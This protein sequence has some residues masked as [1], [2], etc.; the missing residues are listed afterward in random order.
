MGMDLA[1]QSWTGTSTYGILI[2]SEVDVSNRSSIDRTGMSDTFL[3]IF[4][5]ESGNPSQERHYTVAA[6]WCLSPRS[7]TREVLGPTKDRLIASLDCSPSELKGAALSPDTLDVIVPD[8]TTHGYDDTTIRHQRVPWATSK[9]IR[10]T[11]HDANPEL[12]KEVVSDI[13]GTPLKAAELLQTL[14]LASLLTPIF[15]PDQLQQ[16]MFAE[17]KVV[18]DSETWQRP[19]DRIESGIETL[20]MSVPESLSFEIQDSKAAPGIQIS[21]LT[22]YCWLRNRRNDD[23]NEAVNGI[24]NRRFGTF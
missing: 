17:T 1:V 21:D 6:T 13:T 20:D 2:K 18:L 23:C 9:P 8:I 4:V 14:S 15:Y 16:D 3:Y 24:D 22:A 11:I 19:K 5:D 10:H 12:T 7:H